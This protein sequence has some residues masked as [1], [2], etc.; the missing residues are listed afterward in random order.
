MYI[1]FPALSQ[2]CALGFHFMQSIHRIAINQLVT[3][4]LMTI[5]HPTSPKEERVFKNDTGFKVR[6]A[7]ALKSSQYLYNIPSMCDIM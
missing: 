3:I 7:I 6:C 4:V 5:S 1:M 2:K